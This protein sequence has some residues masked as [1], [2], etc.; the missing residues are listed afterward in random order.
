MESIDSN[1]LCVHLKIPT[2]EP[3]GKPRVL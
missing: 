1:E 3:C 2:W